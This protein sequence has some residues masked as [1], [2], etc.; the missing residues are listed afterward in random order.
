MSISPYIAAL[1]TQIGTSRLLLP[2][3]T[4]IVYGNQGEILLV[5]QRDGDI[6]S[7]PGGA[8]EPDESP[9]DAVVRETWEET[10][11]LVNP[12]ALIGVFGGPNFVVRYANGDETQYVMTVFECEHLSGQ[13]TDSTDE[14][15]ACRFVSE[16]E[17]Q[18]LPV[19]PWMREVLPA[20][21]SR[22]RKPII[23]DVRWYP[24][25]PMPSTPSKKRR[26]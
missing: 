21:Y 14:V 11:L 5:H 7:T 18:S 17:F 8:I 10:G 20:C 4:G 15:S 22:P 6:W 24:P 1:R 3:V 9:V 19:S 25:V 12:S 16:V 13:L 23:G 2:S 26:S